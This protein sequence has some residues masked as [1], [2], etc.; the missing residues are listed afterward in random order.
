M[1]SLKKLERNKSRGD[2][3]G[4]WM[5]NKGDQDLGIRSDGKKRQTKS[6]QTVD[7]Y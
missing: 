5:E 3:E 4:L 7:R 2:A 6:P 1:V